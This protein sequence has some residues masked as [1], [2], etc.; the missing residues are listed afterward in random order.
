[1]LQRWQSRP[2]A[3]IRAALLLSV[4]IHL[5]VFIFCKLPTMP[6]IDEGYATLTV[7]ILPPWR[8]GKKMEADRQVFPEKPVETLPNPEPMKPGVNKPAA[9]FMPKPMPLSSKVVR[10]SNPVTT[11]SMANDEKDVPLPVVPGVENHQNQ[12]LVRAQALL[13]VGE[14]GHVQAIVWNR[15]PAVTEEELKRMLSELRAKVFLATG[16]TYTTTEDVEVPR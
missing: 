4:V 7:V 12:S 10:Q 2:D 8:G 15:M 5:A 1:M 9:L 11:E 14:D 16:K 13:L 6:S 3:A